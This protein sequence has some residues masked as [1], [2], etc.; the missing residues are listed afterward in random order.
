MKLWGKVHAKRKVPKVFNL[1]LT[2]TFLKVWCY[3]LWELVVQVRSR[4]KD[5]RFDK[6]TP[7]RRRNIVWVD[8]CVM[9]L[10][11]LHRNLLFTN[12]LL[13]FSCTSLLLPTTCTK[14]GVQNLPEKKTIFKI[15]SVLYKIFLCFFF[16]LFDFWL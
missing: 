6:S 5:D 9:S 16:F 13:L 10:P 4:D 14:E 7:G 2:Q 3:N 12:E 11:C 1:H 15:T 8:K